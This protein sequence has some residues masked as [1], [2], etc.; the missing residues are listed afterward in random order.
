M[1]HLADGKSSE[2]ELTSARHE[3]RKD[4]S[5]RV[6]SRRDAQGSAS[7]EEGG[8]SLTE[9]RAR[10]VIRDRLL[11]RS[12]AAREMLSAMVRD[13]VIRLSWMSE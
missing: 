5:R 1:F 11:A 12:L 2:D 6:R 3:V 7:T 13:H 9:A 4:S 8:G 10:S